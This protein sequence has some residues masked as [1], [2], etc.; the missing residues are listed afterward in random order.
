MRQVGWQSRGERVIVD[1]RGDLPIRLVWRGT[2]YRIE[3]IERSWCAQTQWWLE[4][5]RMGQCRAYFRVSLSSP[6]KQSL[7]VEIYRQRA[8]WLL[9][10]VAD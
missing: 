9:C 8:I 6:S 3:S 10:Q 1:T 2:P 4:P 5:R 7:C